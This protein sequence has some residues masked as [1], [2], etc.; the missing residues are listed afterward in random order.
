MRRP[1][2]EHPTGDK[3]ALEEPDG[4]VMPWEM[5]DHVVADDQLKAVGRERG[6]LDVPQDLLVSIGVVLDLG[7]VDVD[8]HD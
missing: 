8:N 2:Q 6:G 3:R 1:D 7:L 4:V 5:L